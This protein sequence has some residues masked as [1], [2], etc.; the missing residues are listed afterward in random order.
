[1]DEFQRQLSGV[2]VKERRMFTDV[3]AMPAP[4]SLTHYLRGAPSFF[5][6]SCADFPFELGGIMLRRCYQY[7]QE[8]KT[9][10][11]RN[12][13][14]QPDPQQRIGIKAYPYR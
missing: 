3:E 9:M 8:W 2:C 4:R 14:L 12:V 7:R 5:P 1:M 13:Y 10:S 11:R 6:P